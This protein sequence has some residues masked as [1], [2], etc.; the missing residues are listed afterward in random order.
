MRD[1]RR[2]RS[3]SP[4]FHRLWKT[5]KFITTSTKSHY[6]STHTQTHLSLELHNSLLNISILSSHLL[7]YLSSS[8][9]YWGFPTKTSYQFIKLLIRVTCNSRHRLL[10]LTIPIAWGKDRKLWTLTN[11]SVLK[12]RVKFSLDPNI[13]LSIPTDIFDLSDIIMWN[14]QVSALCKEGSISHYS[15][16]LTLLRSVYHFVVYIY[17]YTH[18][19]V[20]FNMYISSWQTGR[21]KILTWK[22]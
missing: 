4:K 10:D 3:A 1:Y 19:S 5:P 11:S 18:T 9:I 22:I 20:Y 13:F 2:T 12:P 6:W 14:N 17:I 21:K 7:L 15:I 8:L 16:N